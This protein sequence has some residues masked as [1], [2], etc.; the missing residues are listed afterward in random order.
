VAVLLTRG[1]IE[2]C[3]SGPGGEPAAIWESDD[4]TYVGQDAGGD[5]G[6]DAVDVH[7]V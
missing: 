4:I 1:G 5:D 6:S 3:G 7:Q 2:G